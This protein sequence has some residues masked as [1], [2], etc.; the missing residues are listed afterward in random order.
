MADD[1]TVK[2]SASKLLKSKTFESSARSR[3]L[4]AYLAAAKST[5]TELTPYAIAF[6][7]FERGDDFDP[8]SDPIVRVQMS[9]LRNLLK[10]YYKTEGRR[11]L[12]R[13]DLPPRRYELS[14]TNNA[15]RAKSADLRGLFLKSGL[16]GAVVI[17]IFAFMLSKWHTDDTSSQPVDVRLPIV[18]VVPFQIT[19]DASQAES[20][21]LGLQQQIVTDLWRF[22]TV[23]PALLGS[24]EQVDHLEPDFVVSGVV[25]QT[26]DD[27]FVTLKLTDFPRGR[28]LWREDSARLFENGQ[29][30][31]LV[32]TISLNASR[33]VGAP[34]GA[35][36]TEML[37][38]IGSEMALG[39]S[40]STDLYYCLLG[41]IEFRRQGAAKGGEQAADCLE[42]L[43]ANGSQVSEVVAASSWMYALSVDP[44][45]NF[46]Q[47]SPQDAISIALERARHAV[48]LDAGS[49]FSHSILAAVHW[50]AGNEEVSILSFERAHALNPGNPEEAASLGLFM[51][52]T[53]HCDEGLTYA[54]EAINTAPKPPPWYHTAFAIHALLNQKP[55][56]AIPHASIL[57]QGSDRNDCAYLVAAAGLAGTVD[58]AERCRAT[59]EANRQ[60]FGDP[61]GGSRVWIRNPELIAILEEG[62]TLS[63]M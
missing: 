41:F 11:D 60:D 31:H 13:L 19:P 29:Y 23:R 47:V 63:G 43:V 56:D 18:A 52:L 15:A 34:S 30:T 42:T 25:S 40:N 55:D 10:A 61:L 33:A 58:A 51:C 5:G 24:L 45:R 9:R 49:S 57:V 44:G 53:T 4:L 3:E 48:T 7:V 17:A 32:S 62:I 12:H 2:V 14:V 59:I 46:H 37:E 1:A 27:V 39:E 21:A 36:S 26:E 16:A 8:S 54:R 28:E 35:I 50:V 6:D 38:R 20:V 22:R